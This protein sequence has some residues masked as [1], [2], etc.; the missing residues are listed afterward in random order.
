[1]GDLPKLL[2]RSISSEHTVSSVRF[3][4]CVIKE[5]E[6][7]PCDGARYVKNAPLKPIHNIWGRR[8]DMRLPRTAKSI[9]AYHSQTSTVCLVFADSRTFALHFVIH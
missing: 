1:M 2:N 9:S 8:E 4:T 6:D 5:F 7:E 3:G